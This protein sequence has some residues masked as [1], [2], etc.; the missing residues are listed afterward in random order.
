MHSSPSGSSSSSSQGISNNSSS[1]S[2]NSSHD[3]TACAMSS[4]CE[5]GAYMHGALEYPILP[6]PCPPGVP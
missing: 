2:N 3:H 6:G 4:S 1:S 5:A